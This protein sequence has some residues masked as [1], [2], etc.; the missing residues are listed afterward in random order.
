MSSE[1]AQPVKAIRA[2]SKIIMVTI[3]FINHIVAD[4]I[5][6]IIDKKSKTLFLK[7]QQ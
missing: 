6:N 5:N 4:N 7:H 2:Y 1:G 3:G